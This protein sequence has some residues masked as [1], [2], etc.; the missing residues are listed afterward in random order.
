[1]ILEFI[2]IASA[3]KERKKARTSLIIF[4]IFMII[5]IIFILILIITM[6]FSV[7]LSPLKFV[8]SLLEYRPTT[9][10]SMRLCI[11]ALRFTFRSTYPS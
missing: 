3:A 2:V 4:I 5:N 9:L 1:M 11:H 10:S 8:L 7:I 6:A